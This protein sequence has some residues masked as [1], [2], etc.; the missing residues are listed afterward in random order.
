MWIYNYNYLTTPSSGWVGRYLV[1]VIKLPNKNHILIHGRPIPH[2]MQSQNN[3][4]LPLCS[5]TPLH[6]F[7]P[8]QYNQCSLI[9]SFISPSS[10]YNNHNPTPEDPVPAPVHPH[11]HSH[12]SATYPI[13]TVVVVPSHPHP[14]SPPLPAPQSP[15]AA[16]R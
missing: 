9:H 2:A 14:P 8:I 6:I 4:Y 15:P 11:T 1:G 10:P 12:P 7:H 5:K 16:P 3:T 13:H